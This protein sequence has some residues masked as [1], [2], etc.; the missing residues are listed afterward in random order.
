MQ[1]RP[2]SVDLATLALMPAIDPEGNRVVPVAVVDLDHADS[3]S[4]EDVLTARRGGRVVVGVATGELS[5]TARSIGEALDTTL[6]PRDADAP[7]WAVDVDDPVAEVERVRLATEANPGSGRALTEVLSMVTGMVGRRGLLVES[8]AYS[9]LLAGPEFGAWLAARSRRPA[10][11]APD[12]LVAVTRDGDAL[13]IELNHPQ[14]RNAY[15][16]RLRDQL[17]DALR[18]A[19][20]DSSVR[21]VVLAGAGP[22]FSA[23]GDLDE[24]GTVAD[25][26]IAHL[27]RTTAGVTG[28]LEDIRSRLEVRVHGTVIG[29]GVEL[30]AF[31]S[32]V[33]AAPGTTFRLPEIS[34][35]LIPGAGGTVSVSRRMG[36]W[37]TAW[38]G[39]TGAEIDA[40]RAHAWGLVDSIE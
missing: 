7:R 19:A 31:G 17:H 34:M 21:R 29:A 3:I 26:V 40:E 32:K 2:S 28:T 9:T 27:V 15:S 6:V 10:K 13:R 20:L 39:L 14:R 36:R 16:A 4:V 35:G 23:G 22:C 33:V 30:A 18:V 38:F 25:P 12:E 24:F 37:R 1:P 5:A 11:P 8:Y